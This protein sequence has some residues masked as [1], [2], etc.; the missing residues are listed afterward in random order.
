MLLSFQL[1]NF[2]LKLIEVISEPSPVDNLST[3]G[4]CVIDRQMVSGI[5][6]P[7]LKSLPHENSIEHI[8]KSL[9]FVIL[10]ITRPHSLSLLL[11]LL[12]RK[13]IYKFLILIL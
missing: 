1:F 4:S 10:S 11:F 13:G 3:L 8:S 7:A 12:R 5:G 6:N 9:E 2:L